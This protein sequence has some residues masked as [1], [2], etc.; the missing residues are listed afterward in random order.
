MRAVKLGLLAVLIVATPLGAAALAQAQGS[1]TAAAVPPAAAESAR[2]VTR[3]G[4]L[5]ELS[6]QSAEMAFVAGR[7]VR[8][9]AQVADDIFAAGRELRVDG[10]SADHL[11]VAGGEIDLAPATVHDLIAAGGRILLRSGVVSDDVVAAGGEI[12]LDRNARIEGSSVLTGGRLR[13]DAPIGRE[14]MAA[15]GEIELNGAVGGDVRLR[16]DEIVIGPQAR[17]AGD[18]H[19]RG[20]RIEISPGAVVQGRTVRE[21]V[22]REKPSAAPF[23]VMGLLFALGV[24]IMIGAIAAAAPRLLQGAER[25]LQSGGWVTLAIGLAIVLLA[26]LVIVALLATVLGAPLGLVLALAYL[27]AIPL[28]FVAVSY[29]LGQVIRARAAKAHAAGPP[30][31]PAR[32]GWTV[33]AALLLMV[34]FVVP[35]VGGLIWLVALAAG[36]GGLAGH[37]FDYANRRPLEPSRDGTAV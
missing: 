14:L 29:W 37:L 11:F 5:S 15:G 23:I 3:H 20:A 26:P 33:L 13:I 4:D 35:L 12:T 36:M 31:W 10:A 22:E 16:G 34:A 19:V 27:L 8:V 2:I 32:V 1:Q 9:T 25:R 6:G 28:A 21:V 17:I 7:R 18:L 30:R 24:L